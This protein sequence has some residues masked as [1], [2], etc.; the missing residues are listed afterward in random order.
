[1]SSRKSELKGLS[2]GAPGDPDDS[3]GDKCVLPAL[4]V[5]GGVV[6]PAT[7]GTIFE[8]ALKAEEAELKENPL[9][10]ADKTGGSGISSWKP[11]RN[12][13]LL[14]PRKKSGI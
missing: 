9:E 14:N 13:M 10:K 3:L 4:P 11:G 5:R 12:D 6:A 8:S 2:V 1:M 7:G